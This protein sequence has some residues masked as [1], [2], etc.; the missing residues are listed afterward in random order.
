MKERGKSGVSGG[1]EAV[2]QGPKSRAHVSLAAG[3]ESCTRAG[4]HIPVT[5]TRGEE[6]SSEDPPPPQ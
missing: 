2:S 4:T 5:K 3:T 6:Q 1:W